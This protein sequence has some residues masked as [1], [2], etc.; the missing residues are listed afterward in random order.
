MSEA[1]S[2]VTSMTVLDECSFGLD[3]GAM[4]GIVPR[5]LWERSI[6]PDAQHRIP[7]RSRLLLLDVDGGIRRILIDTGM[8]CAWDPK[9]RAIYAVEHPNGSL[10]DHLASLGVPAESVTDVVLTHLHFDHAG[11]LLREDGRA[12]F[13]N[14]THHVQRE[15]WV[16]A[17]HPTLR[18]AGSYR[19][20]RF[21]W[22]G[23]GGNLVLHDGLSRVADVLTLHPMFGHTPG[24]QIVD[25][26]YQSQRYLH[27]ADLVPTAAHV[28]LAWV[29]GYDLHPA[30]T[31]REK[32]A[33]YE[34][35]LRTDAILIP[36]HDPHR[37]FVRV[38]RRGPDR[39]AAMAV[40]DHPAG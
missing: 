18:D 12:S 27:V 11:G 37:A 33:L 13:P 22:L 14:A 31:V 35:A 28:P 26:E 25:F 20:D 38:E 19:R 16:W 29:M 40:G 21:G 5:P 34:D 9:E 3:G 36:G 17:H 30:T 15:N 1:P 8:G 2:R 10:N 32:Y 6:P 4:F 24:M 39:Y 7:M 23:V